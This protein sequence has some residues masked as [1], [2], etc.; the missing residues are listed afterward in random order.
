MERVDRRDFTVEA[1]G[2]SAQLTGAQQGDG[3]DHLGGMLV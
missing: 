3:R 1:A 2:I